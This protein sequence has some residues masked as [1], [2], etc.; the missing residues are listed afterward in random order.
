MKKS[1]D[2]HFLVAKLA[3]SENH[4][5]VSSL[6]GWFKTKIPDAD[7][8][9]LLSFHA[10]SDSGGFSGETR[11][12]N[13]EWLE[14]GRAAEK[15]VVIRSE[16][17]GANAPESSFHKM[18]SLQKILG[19]IPDLPVPQV[20]W[21]EDDISVIGGPFFVMDFIEGKAAPDSPPF[22]SA[23]WVFE[24]SKESRESMYHSGLEFLVKLHSLDWQN[25]GLGF[26]MHEGD[27]KTQTRRHLDL[28]VSIYDR[29]T[30]GNRTSL[31]DK[32]IDWL[33]RHVPETEALSISWGD[34]RLGN[35]L[36][37]DFKCV[38]AL[39]WEL[40]TLAE[41]AADLAWW[42]FFE[43]ATTEGLGLTRLDGM[44]ER[45]QMI[46]FYE[47]LSNTAV[48]N[49]CYHEI[50]AGFRALVTVT[51]MMKIWERAGQQLYGPGSSIEN[52]PIAATLEQVMMETVDR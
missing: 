44:L 13:I 49:F 15:K 17:H 28:M 47:S 10:P 8:L 3:T 42:I 45:D 14:G 12:A 37:R 23:G 50:F 20:F 41:P 52:N 32:S 6:A 29:A 40:C 21:S 19:N 39:D 24:A 2:E 22:A 51:H 43:K 16:I 18:V 31:A 48:A 36:W 35:M 33:Y 46:D 38:A 26:L 30:E 1:Y 11:I 4:E 7:N 5:M 34:A 27:G 25:L 9:K